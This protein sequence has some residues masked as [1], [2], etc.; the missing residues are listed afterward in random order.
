M[1][2]TSA[3]IVEWISIFGFSHWIRSG[4]NGFIIVW[5]KKN[6]Q[7]FK[8]E[9]SLGSKSHIKS[10]VHFMIPTM[11]EDYGMYF[12]IEWCFT[13]PPSQRQ[14]LLFP[15]YLLQDCSGT[16]NIMAFGLHFFTSK[17][18]LFVVVKRVVC[19]WQV[20]LTGCELLCPQTKPRE[21]CDSS[22]DHQCGLEEGRTADWSS[23]AGENQ[24]RT[25]IG[26]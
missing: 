5:W 8:F 13:S 2:K 26:H 10:S 4:L 1:K 11:S 14:I 16:L 18:L 25:I 19:I 15:F 21:E 3:D 9:H 20:V 17:R 22:A 7:Q 23:N 6:L 24:V 12:K